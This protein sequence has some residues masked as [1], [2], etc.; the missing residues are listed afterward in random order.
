MLS[1]GAD[2]H[3]K[4]NTIE[5]QEDSRKCLWRGTVQNT[6]EDFERLLMKLVQLQSET[7]DSIVGVYINPTGNYHM[8]LE[9]FLKQHG[10]NVIEVNPIVS[11]SIRN[12]M[13]MGKVKSDRTDASVLAS[14]PWVDKRFAD[15]KG[16]V[17]RQLSEL[18]RARGR[19]VDM[20]TTLQNMIE[21]SLAAVFPE[22]LTIIN[23]FTS[24]TVIALLKRCPTPESILS[25][26]AE[27][28]EGIVVKAS[29][30]KIR[31]DF[32]TRLR[33]AASGSIGVPDDEGM[34][35]CKI[36]EYARLL[37]EV[38]R[39]VNTVERKIYSMTENNTD[40]KLIDDIPGI[41]TVTAAAIWAEAGDMSQFESAEK[42]ISYC[43]CSPGINGSGG[44]E[45]GAH[46][47]KI[48]NRYLYDAISSAAWSLVNH[49]TPEFLSVFRREIG[50]GKTREQAYI[51]VGKRL[52]A[53]IFRILSNN[54]P[55]RES[56][57]SDSRC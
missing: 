32:A 29:N 48:S 50:K 8:P 28:L 14:T 40:V 38:I 10:Y 7:S 2:T 53:H 3:L 24:R 12:V 36:S 5:V 49:D 17:R 39:S 11:A 57:P 19:L 9:F 26:P 54:L 20:K 35:E 18:T 45:K 4:S 13:N 22:M 23:V 37:E 1:M 25:M 47:S 16:H 51:V 41:D 34:F 15:K 27:A 55:Y 56:M 33:N 52:S 30:N 6:R 31:G 21:S 43:G 42:L 46:V 44:K